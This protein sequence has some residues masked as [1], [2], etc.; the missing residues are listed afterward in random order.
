MGQSGDGNGDKR[1]ES[2][3]TRSIRE[4]LDALGAELGEVER[5][6][7]ANEPASTEA[8]SGALG[9]AFRLGV[10]MVAGVAVGGVVGWALDA[11]L[12]TAPGFLI[13]FLLLGSG[14]GILNSVR[15]AKRMQVREDDSRPGGGKG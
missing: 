8:R 1:H 4:R 12:G 7:K 2:E 14:A 5:R 6:R 3:A 13:V 15:T 10:E 11:W 9:M